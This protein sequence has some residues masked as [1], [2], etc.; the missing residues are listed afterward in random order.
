MLQKKADEL[1]E[2]GAVIS[3]DVL[4]IMGHIILAHHGQYEFGSPKLPATAEAFMV[5]YIDDMDAK[6]NQVTNAID[7]EPGDSN[8]TGWQGSLGTRLYRKALE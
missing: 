8:W 6:M 7:D 5:N 4:D 3:K 2:K 1:A